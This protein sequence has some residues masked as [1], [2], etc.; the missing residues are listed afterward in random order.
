MKRLIRGFVTFIFLGV[1]VC[2]LTIPVSAKER[3]VEQDTEI[4]SEM[5]DGDMYMYRD[6]SSRFY[7]APKNIYGKRKPFYKIKLKKRSS[8][9]K[10]SGQSGKTDSKKK[11]RLQKK[12]A[13]R[14]STV[15]KKKP[16]KKKIK[17]NRK[18]R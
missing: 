15:K 12:S 8:E 3:N 11:S 2:S 17:K 1:L 13:K 14:K 6:T 10:R 16:L 9:R 18:Q 4:Q 7:R 5:E